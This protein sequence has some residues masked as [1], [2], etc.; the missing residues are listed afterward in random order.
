MLRAAAKNHERITVVVDP[1]DYPAVLAALKE[2]EVPASLRRDLAI[3]AFGH[4]AR[5]DTA[6]SNYLRTHNASPAPWPD[7][8]LTSWRL[9]Q[10]LRYGENPHQQAALY[11]TSQPRAGHRRARGAGPRQGAVVQQHRR[12][13]RGVP[14]RE[15]VRRRRVRDRQ[16]REPVRRRRRRDARAAR[17]RSRT[18][19]TRL[20][21][22]AA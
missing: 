9:A 1:A 13:R 20:P 12:R 8:L 6:I 2:P 10:P 5:Y 21:R 16:A 11:R 17:T 15:R 22:S 14:G 3:K 19:P 7:P 18:A 4:T